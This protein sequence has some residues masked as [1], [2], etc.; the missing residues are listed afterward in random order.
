M[1]APS[2]QATGSVVSS[3]DALTVVWPTHQ[4]DDVALLFVESA[5][6][7]VTLSTAAGF[8]AV[9]NQG[10]GTGGAAAATALYVFWCR[11]TSAAQASPVVADSGARQTAFIMTFRGCIKTGNPWD[12]LGGSVAAAASASV[13]IPTVTTTVVNTLLV[14]AVSNSLGVTAPT[15]RVATLSNGALTNLAKR[16]NTQL[17]G[18]GGTTTNNRLPVGFFSFGAGGKFGAVGQGPDLTTATPCGAC[19]FVPNIADIGAQID[20]A[21]AGN[22]LLLLQ[23]SGNKANFTTTV[24]GVP[25]LDMTKYEAN[26]R[27]FRPDNDNTAFA[28]R[29]KFADAVRR[30]RIIF[31][32]IDE[33]NLNQ[34]VVSNVPD[35]TPTQANQMGLLHKTIWAGYDPLTLIRVPAETMASGWKTTAGSFGRPPGGWTG[36]D[37]CWN[38]YTLRHGRGNSVGKPWSTPRSPQE[39]RDEQYDIIAANNLDLGVFESLNM[40]AGGIGLD[41]PLGVTAKWDTDG[42]GGGST[43]GYVTGSLSTTQDALTFTTLVD[44]Q[45]SVLS[46]PDWIRKHAELAA[47]DSRCPGLLYWMHIY[48]GAPADEYINF[49]Q[50]AD[51]QSAFADAIAFGN[52]RT[53]F[54]GWRDAK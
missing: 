8:V 50:R 31:Y 26:V 9:T 30:R 24:N 17:D 23:P 33:P 27:K 40:T 25:T 52:A 43:L 36:F 5:N 11:A 38:Q 13:S 51:F 1:P 4:A 41:S 34:G 6:Q 32:V 37:Y 42:P 15:V 48:T 53:S 29:L 54:D 47:Q 3:T 10:T 22:I 16:A 35:I 44:S 19:M 39:V 18:T 2:Y 12:V 49:Y 45:G 21:D 7:A 14:A 20:A 28:D 46:N